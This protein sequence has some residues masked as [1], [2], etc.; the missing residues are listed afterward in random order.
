[1]AGINTTTAIAIWGALVSTVLA[2]IRVREH[3][4]DR[5]DVKVSFTPTVIGSLLGV[6]TECCEIRAVNTGRRPVTIAALALQL[7]DGC[8]FNP[9]KLECYSR[10]DLPATL[11]ESQSLSAVLRKSEIDMQKVQ[12]AFARDVDGKVYKSKRF[13]WSK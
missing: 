1:M 4:R 11:T 3:F 5:P 6:M 13:K 12:W 2:V 10:H 9:A 7:S 8:T